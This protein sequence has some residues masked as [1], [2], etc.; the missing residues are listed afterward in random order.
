MISVYCCHYHFQKNNFSPAHLLT[1][2]LLYYPGHGFNYIIL[3][4]HRK[5][6]WWWWSWPCNLVPLAF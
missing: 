4:L 6:N 1:E 5:E 2:N 3:I